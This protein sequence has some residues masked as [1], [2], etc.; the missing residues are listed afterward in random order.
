[1]IVWPSV[2]RNFGLFF[3]NEYVFSSFLKNV[4]FFFSTILL[5]IIHTIRE[6]EP[7]CDTL[8]EQQVMRRPRKNPHP[9]RAVNARTV[10]KGEKE[11]PVLCLRIP[12]E[13]DCE[14]NHQIQKEVEEEGDEGDEDDDDDDVE[15]L[16]RILC[17]PCD[18]VVEKNHQMREEETAFVAKGVKR[19]RGHE[20]GVCEK[21]FRVPSALAIHMRTHTKEKPYECDVCEKRFTTSG[22]LK[23]H[24]RIHTN[25]M[26]ECD[27]CEKSFTQAGNLKRHRRIHANEKPY[28]CDVCE[29][30]FTQSSS[31]KIHMRT[32]TKEKPFECHVCEKRYRYASGL[33]Y[34][35]RTQH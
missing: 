8:K 32:H 22:S 33:K 5:L 18:D 21:V 35:M 15:R 4:S 10:L 7:L 26:F 28:E 27:L 25:E 3:P 20:C 9:K 1:M 30:R 34:H 2:L 16:R 14:A 13:D 11:E 23:V 17:V 6:K 19:K 12:V 31:L 24:M 29:K